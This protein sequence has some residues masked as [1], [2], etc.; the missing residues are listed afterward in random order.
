[1][2][3]AEHEILPLLSVLVVGKLL[4]GLGFLL[5]ELLQKSF[6]EGKGD[7]E[8]AGLLRR[9]RWRRRRRPMSERCGLGVCVWREERERE[10]RLESQKGGGAY[11]VH[12]S[13]GKGMYKSC[14]CWRNRGGQRIKV[15]TS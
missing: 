10:E 4:L 15:S 12:G 6:V 9:R 11:V 7:R 8:R 5:G 14:A 3:S 13:K 2:L 1:M